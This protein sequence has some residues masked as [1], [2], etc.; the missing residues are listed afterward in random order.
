MTTT[1]HTLELLIVLVA[2]TGIGLAGLLA[3]RGKKSSGTVTYFLASRDVGWPALSISLAMTALWGIVSLSAGLGAPSDGPGLTVLGVMAAGGLVIFGFLFAPRYRASHAATIPAFLAERYGKRVGLAV[4]VVSVVITLF[5]QIPFTILVASRLLNALLGWEFMS[6]ALLM[7]V[8]PGLCVV[9]RGYHGVIGMQSAGGIVCAVGLL[10]LALNGYSSAHPLLAPVLSEAGIPWAMLLPGIAV[11]GVWYTCIDQFA[12]HRSFVA[13][14]SA[15]VRNSSGLAAGLV[16]L[17]IVGAAAGFERALSPAGQAMAAD[18]V[19]AGILGA[20]IIS[21][22][23]AS[24]SGYFMSVATL[25]TVDG[26]LAHRK[27][28]DE[29]ALVTVGRLTN[30]AAA[31]LAI[32][33]ASSVAFM[34]AGSIEWMIRAVVVAV[35]PVVAVTTI[36]LFW[37]RMHG[38]GASW[39][40][41][42]G[43][44]AGLFQVGMSTAGIAG[45]MQAAL[46]TF[47]C[48]ALVLVAVSLVS[49]PVGALGTMPQVS[50][51]E[52]LGVRR[53]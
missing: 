50:L 16:V 5:I 49:A 53:T 18:N 9:A 8:V 22:G 40:L 36:G 15:A 26:F 38:R 31:L 23:V 37:L 14:S 34:G 41:G 39:A 44:L 51:E 24:L 12:A 33:A 48:S 17:A 11:L 19:T 42:V 28:C 1:P 45:L 20:A 32:L 46:L 21:F 10:F 30:T 47:L 27:R 7:I 3:P 43:W 35:P 13:R 25:F 52:G 4:A 29:V 6:S 2:L